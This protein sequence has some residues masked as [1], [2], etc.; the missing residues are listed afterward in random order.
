MHQ[1]QSHVRLVAPDDDRLVPPF[2]PPAP[3]SRQQL[4]RGFKAPNTIPRDIA[5]LADEGNIQLKIPRGLVDL[6]RRLSRQGFLGRS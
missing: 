5:H 6:L 1:C 2:G 4:Y 3:V